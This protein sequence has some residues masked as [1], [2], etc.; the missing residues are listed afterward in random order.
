MGTLAAQAT[1]F[2][3]RASPIRSSPWMGAAYKGTQNSDL[4]YRQDI[5]LVECRVLRR[6]CRVPSVHT[7]QAMICNDGLFF[8]MY[9]ICTEEVWERNK[10]VWSAVRKKV[11]GI[12]RAGCPG[13]QYGRYDFLNDFTSQR[14]AA[15]NVFT[16]IAGQ[17]SKWRFHAI[18]PILLTEKC[19][20]TITVWSS[21]IATTCDSC[22][23]KIGCFC[24][25]ARCK[26]QVDVHKGSVCKLPEC[27]EV[28][29][30]NG[31]NHG[32]GLL[33]AASAWIFLK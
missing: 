33:R 6:V 25:A 11:S 29:C 27:T 13:G 8:S 9:L 14:M 16:K 18:S 7:S 3:T 4:V 28:A 21:E 22:T 32:V 23:P 5:D 17:F 19:H 1:F 30:G 2:G 20:G 24:V 31:C 12:S 15:S 10:S 26:S